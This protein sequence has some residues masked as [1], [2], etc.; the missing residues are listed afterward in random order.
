MNII[1]S[2]TKSEIISFLDSNYPLMIT[3]PENPNIGD[4]WILENRRGQLG[5]FSWQEQLE[6]KNLPATG[7]RNLVY[8]EYTESGDK[9]NW[10]TVSIA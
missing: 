10:L 7:S 4:K 2:G 6:S 5:A 9:S 8:K 3:R 1:Y